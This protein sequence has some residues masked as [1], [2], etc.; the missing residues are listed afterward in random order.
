MATNPDDLPA[1]AGGGGHD[2]KTNAPNGQGATS[3]ENAD[4]EIRAA[5]EAGEYAAAVAG[6]DPEAAAPIPADDREAL[7]TPGTG[8]S[9]PGDSE[10]NTLTPESLSTDAGGG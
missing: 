4:T 7:A 3:P 8:S 10:P 2:D 6:D 1:P 5:R 9:A